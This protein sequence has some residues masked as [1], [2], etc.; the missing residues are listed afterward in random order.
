MDMELM[1]EF[2]AIEEKKRDLDSQLKQVVQRLDDIE[3]QIVPQMLSDGVSQMRVDGRTIYIANKIYAGPKDGDKG[4]V[5][6]A[7][8]SSDDTAAFVAENY[9]AQTLR[10]YVSEIAK[11]VETV[12]KKDG[13]LFDE[14]AIRAALPTELAAAIKISFVHSL[15]S[16]KA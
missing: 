6:D 7:L 16:R 2:V 15:H 13:R 9:N 8:K 3:E 5:I 11:E 12:C 1:R 14:E 4:S 10:S